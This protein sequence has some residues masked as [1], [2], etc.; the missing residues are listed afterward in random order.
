MDPLVL[1]AEMART[2]KEMMKRRKRAVEVEVFMIGEVQ[3]QFQTLDLRVTRW[4]ATV[5]R[6]LCFWVTL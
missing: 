4:S 5:N 6:T 1:Q 2:W 3:V